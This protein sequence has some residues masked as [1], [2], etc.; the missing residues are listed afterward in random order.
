MDIFGKEEEE[1][2]VGPGVEKDEAEDK[3]R[4]MPLKIIDSHQIKE[5]KIV[6][7]NAI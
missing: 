7:E 4:V 5:D 1:A 6:E 3:I 2:A